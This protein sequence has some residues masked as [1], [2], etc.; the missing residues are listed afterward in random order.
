MNVD[1]AQELLNELGS[2]LENLEK[3]HGALLQLLKDKDI[4][5]DDQLAPYLA[6]AGKASNVRWLAARI[7]LEHLFSAEKQR[8]EKLAEEQHK[9]VPAQEPAQDHPEE[10]KSK[11]DEGKG[12]SKPQRE[13]SA[14]DAATESA[15]NKT[16]TKRDSE[17]HQDATSEDKKTSPKQEK[18]GA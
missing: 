2:S 1:L 7:R 11:N 16:D 17:Q 12:E 8:E 6:Q 9:A 10:A 3:Q 18:N 5:T 13:A 14:I 15:G 4:V